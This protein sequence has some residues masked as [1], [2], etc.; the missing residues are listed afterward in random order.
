MGRVSVPKK[1]RIKMEAHLCSKEL[2]EV[3]YT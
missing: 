2:T 3:C 1:N